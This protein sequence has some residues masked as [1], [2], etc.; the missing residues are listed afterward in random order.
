MPRLTWSVLV[1]DED[2]ASHANDLR[3][4]AGEVITAA[5]SPCGGMPSAA[6]PGCSVPHLTHLLLHSPT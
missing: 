4:I 1:H 6:P 3:G 2:E 5:R